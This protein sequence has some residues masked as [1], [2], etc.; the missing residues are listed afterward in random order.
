MSMDL[1]PPT[2][3]QPQTAKLVFHCRVCR[4][5]RPGHKIRTVCVTRSTEDTNSG[6]FCVPGG[7]YQSCFIKDFGRKHLDEDQMQKLF[8]LD[9]DQT[10]NTKQHK[11]PKAKHKTPNAKCVLFTFCILF[12]RGT[13]STYFLYERVFP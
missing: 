3:L 6:T 4:D 13:Q 7:P 1:G 2:Q 8:V 11:T 9:E 12:P 5:V 10:Q